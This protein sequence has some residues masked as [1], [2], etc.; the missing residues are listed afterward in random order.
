MYGHDCIKVAP[1]RKT[2]RTAGA[3]LEWLPRSAHRNWALLKVFQTAL[4]N[5][6]DGRW[7]R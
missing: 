1:L 4:P 7:C 3:S 5:Q 2:Q 6:V